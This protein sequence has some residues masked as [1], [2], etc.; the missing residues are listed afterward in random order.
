MEIIVY[1]TTTC[2]YCNML[3]S[4]LKERSVAFEEKVV[5]QDD[6]AKEEMSNI[7]DGFLGVPFTTITKDDG[8]KVNIIGFDRGKLD[9]TLGTS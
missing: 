4:Y 5:D 6:V 2:P 8:T 3:K 7:S 9:E 1:T